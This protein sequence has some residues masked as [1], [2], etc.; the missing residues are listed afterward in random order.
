MKGLSCIAFRA[1]IL[2]VFCLLRL[3]LCICVVCKC[4]CVVS[5]V[6]VCC[7]FVIG[8]LVASF[9]FGGFAIGFFWSFSCFA[10]FLFIILLMLLLSLV[11][12]ICFG[13]DVVSSCVLVWICDWFV[14]ILV[15]VL[16]LSW[17]FGESFDGRVWLSI[18]WRSSYCPLVIYCLYCWYYFFVDRNLVKSYPD[19]IFFCFNW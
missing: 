13:C 10:S 7:F 19:V 4:I 12:T 2:D 3:S 16:K 9:F 15:D 14:K 5:R 1:V 17:H 18:F 6:F 8:H 11:Y